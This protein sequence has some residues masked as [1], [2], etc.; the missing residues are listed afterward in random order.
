[1]LFNDFG[2][3]EVLDKNGEEPVES[4]IE[5]I[6]NEEEG[7]VTLMPNQK[8]VYEDGEMV[9]ISN[10]KGMELKDPPGSSIN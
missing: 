1:M 3:L 6:T 2:T 9:K 10:V 7:V 5:K 8:H 4:F